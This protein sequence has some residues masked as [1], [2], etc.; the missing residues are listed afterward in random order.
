MISEKQYEKA[1]E[2]VR[3]YETQSKPETTLVRATF[4][5]DLSVAV[6]VPKKWSAD[7]VLLELETN[8][9]DDLEVVSNADIS[10]KGVQELV[11]GGVEIPLKK[12]PKF[13]EMFQNEPCV[14]HSC[15]MEGK[16][17]KCSKTIDK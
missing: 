7:E 11:I 10:L 4:V 16:C 1:L 15:D 13:A 14:I 6:R 8:G 9:Y 2:V 3:K 5:A 12:K 17:F